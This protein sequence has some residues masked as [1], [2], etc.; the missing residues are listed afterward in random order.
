MTRQKSE[1]PIVPEG[2]RKFASTALARGGKGVSVD[3]EREQLGLPF[4]TAVSRK[5]TTGE[6][7]AQPSSR[8][9]PKVDVQSGT[10]LPATMDVVVQNLDEA[11]IH[12]VRNKGAAGS[13]GMGVED[14]QQDWDSIC[15]PLIRSL[16]DGTYR[17]GAARRK[18]IPKP[19]GGE[20]ALSIPNVVDRV[21]QQALKAALQPQ[22]EPDFSDHSHGFRPRRSCHTAII[23]AQAYVTEGYIVVVDLDLSKFFDRVNHQRL[24]AQ[25]ARKVESRPV[26]KLLNRILQS[27]TLMPDGLIV[28]SEEGVPQGG[29]LSPLLSNI[30]LDELDKEL[31]CRG[32]RFVRYADDIAIFVRSE[33][34]GRRVMQSVTRFI[35]GRMRLRVNET[36][37][38]V[39]A[40]DEGNL[41]G[42]RWVPCP[43]GA[44]EIDLSD[45]TMKRAHARIRELTPRNWGRSLWSC[46]HKLNRYFTG[47]F[48]FFGICTKMARRRLKELDGRARRRIRAL[49][50]KQWKQRRTIFRKLNRM[51]YSKGVAKAVYGKRRSWWALSGNA[52]VS[53]RLN[54]AWMLR[55]GLESLLERHIER[56]LSMVVPIQSGPRTQ[57]YLWNELR[58]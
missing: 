16:W 55:R 50:L 8:R 56:A 31:M 15:R 33:R 23:E 1:D 9:T 11:L 30:V 39:R 43:D 20:R 29:P 10:A 36:K 44:V 37:S 12:V 22:F 21:V 45:R 51:K 25:V 14:V 28:Q 40:P 2:A 47:W 19:G 52:A 27:E 54:T 53:H 38:S 46:L 32:H 3:E 17:P 6:A 49:Q 4:T 41:L 42:F 48:G 34:A 5:G 7:L 35:E 26:M 57:L 58:S 24:L 13:D 18:M